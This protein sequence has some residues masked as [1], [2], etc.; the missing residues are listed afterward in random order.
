M[1]NR[2]SIFLNQFSLPIHLP[3]FSRMSMS[4]N[5]CIYSFIRV[6]QCA[7]DCFNSFA[8]SKVQ[9]DSSQEH[10]GNSANSSPTRTSTTLFIGDYIPAPNVKYHHSIYQKQYTS[11][12]DLTFCLHKSIESACLV[13]SSNCC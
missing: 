12:N 3:L 5:H 13:P 8:Q 9:L 7:C 2:F 10:T 4:Y 6:R 1:I 11:L